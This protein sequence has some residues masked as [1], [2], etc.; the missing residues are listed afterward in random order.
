MKNCILTTKYEQTVK[1]EHCSV[2]KGMGHKPFC[3]LPPPTIESGGT[4]PPFSYA[5]VHIREVSF[6]WCYEVPCRILKIKC[7]LSTLHHFC[8]KWEGRVQ[9]LVN[10][11]IWVT[12]LKKIALQALTKLC[13][14]SAWIYSIWK[15]SNCRNSNGLLDFNRNGIGL[16]LIGSAF[17]RDQQLLRRSRA[18]TR[19]FLVYTLL[20]NPSL[21]YSRRTHQ[22]WLEDWWTP[23]WMLLLECAIYK[24]ASHGTLVLA[25]SWKCHANQKFTMR[26][27]SDIGY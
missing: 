20:K 18:R 13:I 8:G 12:D 5:S 11:V 2:Q 3:A 21:Q 4:P 19:W 25:C 1:L 16:F 22:E 26:T 17:L 7:I 10:H 6:M 15:I 23:Y 24:N 9:K 27:D 14:I